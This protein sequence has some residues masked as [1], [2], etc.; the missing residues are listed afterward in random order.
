MPARDDALHPE[1][2]EALERGGPVVAL[3]S[4]LIAHGLPRPTNLEV[5]RRAEQ[6]VRAAGAVPATIAV[7]GGRLRIGLSDA[8]LDRLAGRDGVLKAGRR[9]LAPA[10]SAGRDAATTVSATLWIARRAGIP[11]FATG[12][13]GGV[14]RGAAES[15]DISTDLDELAR[16]DG[17]LVVCSGAK[18][19]LD[20]P[21]TLEA[22]ETRGVLVVGYRTGEW[23]AFTE[24]GSGLP[25]EHR[26]ESAEQAAALVAAHRS[27][28]VP[29]A[30]VLAQPVPEAEAVAAGRMES[31]LSSAL[32]E[33]RRRKIVGKALTPFLL[34]RIHEGSG[35][36]SLTANAALIVENAALA[37]RVAVRLSEREESG[38]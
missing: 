29:G 13:L 32:A 4:T 9:D 28:G 31:G 15:F 12:G 3:E 19:I 14:H 33:A 26:V 24:R 34:G 17:C 7:I 2:A 11:V 10:I 18:T 38:R 23:P 20:L 37:A 35:G 5:A 22:L 6:E 16:A 36:E 8:E 25:L 1:V 30:V 21:A 27:L